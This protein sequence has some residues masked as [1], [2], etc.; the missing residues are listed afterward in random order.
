MEQGEINMTKNEFLLDDGRKAEEVRIVKP[1]A[2]V[3]EIYAEPK[4][5]I[6]EVEKKLV[7]R[8]TERRPCGYEKEIELY[9]ETTGE[10]T[11][12]VEKQ[13]CVTKQEV[14]QMIREYCGEKCCGGKKTEIAKVDKLY[15]NG[16]Q[17]TIDTKS[18]PSSNFP[19]RWTAMTAKKMLEDKLNSKSNVMSYVIFGVIAL[20]VAALAWILL[21]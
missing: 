13:E 9:D 19:S 3:Q 18:P 21:K 14:E 1:D 12:I 16:T 17:W 8:I 4:P 20:Q 6:K 15:P 10:V 7:K 2:V 5:V 11:R